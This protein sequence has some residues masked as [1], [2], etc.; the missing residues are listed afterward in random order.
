[1]SDN[2]NAMNGALAEFAY[3]HGIISVKEYLFADD[4]CRKR[5]LSVRQLKWRRAINNK[6]LLATRV[7][8]N[9]V[10]VAWDTPK[11]PVLS[12]R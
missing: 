4:T 12:W 2:A 11:P 5:N 8:R 10:P 7:K 9:I 6:V 1:M 3:E